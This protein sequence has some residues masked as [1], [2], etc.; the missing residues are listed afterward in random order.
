MTKGRQHYGPGSGYHEF[1]G[2]DASVPYITG[3]FTKEEAEKGTEVLTLKELSGL[4]SWRDFYRNHPEY[5]F[6][7]R[8]IDPRY[9]DKEGNPTHEMIN[10]EARLETA[11]QLRKQEQQ[12]RRAQ[13]AN[14]RKNKPRNK[15]ATEI[16]TRLDERKEELKK[17]NM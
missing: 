15:S 9:Y 14:R 5:K 3:T 8:L 13:R 6:V 4:P 7:G 16:R 10:F 17:R 11:I 2:C 12:E 1:L